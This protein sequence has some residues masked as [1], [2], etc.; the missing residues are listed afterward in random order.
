M[1][2]GPGRP[3]AQPR[4]SMRGKY[5]PRRLPPYQH[6][7]GAL[8]LSKMSLRIPTRDEIFCGFSDASTQP[9]QTQVML[10]YPCQ[11]PLHLFSGTMTLQQ[12]NN[13][14]YVVVIFVREMRIVTDDEW[15][16]I[17]EQDSSN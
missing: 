16:P 10:L 6:D 13:G 15:V 14:W 12:F 5:E 2:E 17:I 8:A 3:I 9:R 4:S 7:G 1:G 11:M